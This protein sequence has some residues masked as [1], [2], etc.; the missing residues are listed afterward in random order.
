MTIKKLTLF[1]IIGI[2]LSFVSFSFLFADTA[3]EGASEPSPRVLESMLDKARDLADAEKLDEAIEM[4]RRV[5]KVDPDNIDALMLLK[6]YYSWSEQGDKTILMLERLLELKPDDMELR[7]E[8]AQY[9]AWQDQ[10]DMAIGEYEKILSREPDNIEERKKLAQ[11][12]M[13]N[14]RMKEA[15]VQYEMLLEED[16]DDLEIRKTLAELYSGSEMTDKAIEQ[17]EAILK[18]DL[19]DLDT[20]EKLA[21]NYMWQERHEKAIPLFKEVLEKDPDRDEARKA[22][23]DMYMWTDRSHL[24]I[25]EYEQILDTIETNEEKERI[26]QNLGESLYSTRSYDKAKEY[27]EQLLTVDPTNIAVQRRLEDIERLTNPQIF[28]QAD[29]FR[30]H[31]AEKRFVLTSGATVL[32]DDN[33]RFSPQ[34]VYNKRTEPGTNRFISHTSGFTLSKIVDEDLSFFTGMGVKYYNIRKSAI[35]YFLRF[36]ENVGDRVTTIIEYNKRIEDDSELELRQRVN[37][38]NLMVGIYYDVWDF[39]ALNTTLLG[40]YYTEGK[41]PDDNYSFTTAISPIIHIVK[42]PIVDLSYT[43]YRGDYLRRSDESIGQIYEYYSPRLVE[44][45]SG[46][47]YFRHVFFDVLDVIV[48]DTVSYTGQGDEDEDHSMRNTIYAEINYNVTKDDSIKV[49]YIRSR[50]FWHIADSYDQTDQISVRYS[51]SF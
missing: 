12:Y 10:A 29:F 14:D 34:Y 49:Y 15:I 44:T 13:W 35:D 48:S 39:L 50:Q 41:A 18:R 30:A 51:H 16:P 6:D 2:T 36:V 27:Y 46:T 19:D 42:K 47:L 26:Y 33:W 5:L 21:F 24:A 11:F 25:E 22:L 7:K 20:K 45:H 43:Y 1:L 23:A 9:Y 40:S 31:G 38:H 17:Y 8:L 28:S 32:L 37:R 4:C 3:E